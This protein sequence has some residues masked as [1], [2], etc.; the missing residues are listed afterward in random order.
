ML[1][2]MS[3]EMPP[4]IKALVELAFITVAVRDVVGHFIIF[5]LLVQRVE[6]AFA[7]NWSSTEPL[8]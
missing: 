1:H 6:F 2:D 7:S 3:V 5:I 4:V 8:Y